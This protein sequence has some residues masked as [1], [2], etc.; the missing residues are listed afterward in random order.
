MQTPFETLDVA[1]DAGDEAIKKAYLR[2]VREFPPERDAEG[3]RRVRA[4]FELI[5]TEASRREYRLFHV[6]LPEPAALS[7]LAFK[8]GPTARPAARDLVGA[9]AESLAD[10]LIDPNA[11]P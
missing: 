2:K 10:D 4:A 11:R 8:P 9:L 1:E 5:E 6:A 7:R 3:F